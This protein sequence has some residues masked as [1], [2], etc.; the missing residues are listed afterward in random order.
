[1]ET[2]EPGAPFLSN[3]PVPHT[4]LPR[5]YANEMHGKG[6]GGELSLGWKAVSRWRVNASYSFLR[7]SLHLNPGSHDPGATLE[8]GDNPRH[9]LQIRSQLDLPH[10]A[11]F[12]ASLYYVGKLLDQSV[13][14]YTRLDLRLG[15]HPRESVDL[16]VIGQNLLQPRHLEFLNNTGLVPTYD[17]RRVFVRLTWRISH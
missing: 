16:D 8:E 10:R 5:Y 14:A 12:D 4:V 1:L 7:Q 6:Y 11:E 15:W 17:P 9:Q 2:Q 3:N 13:P